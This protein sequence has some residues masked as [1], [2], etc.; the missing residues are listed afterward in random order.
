MLMKS[1]LVVGESISDKTKVVDL[2][3]T[4]K[5]PFGYYLLLAT[6]KGTLELIPALLQQSKYLIAKDSVVFGIA[7]NKKEAKEMICDI[8]SEIYVQHTHDS[9]EAYV[10]DVIGEVIC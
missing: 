6:P 7:K 1:E 9:V 3:K 2:F 8:L 5:L 10:R 4:G